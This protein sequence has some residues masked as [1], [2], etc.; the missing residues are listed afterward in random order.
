MV[1]LY[2]RVLVNQYDDADLEEGA[3]NAEAGQDG[4]LTDGTAGENVSKKS[5]PERQGYERQPES[6]S[7]GS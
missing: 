6:E 7:E 3:E 4:Q 2:R 1:N 5:M